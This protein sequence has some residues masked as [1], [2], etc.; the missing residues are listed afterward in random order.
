[1]SNKVYYSDM[2]SH[3]SH[4]RNDPFQA[5][6]SGRK[7]IESRLYD[8]KRQLITVGDS[9]TYINNDT[10]EQSVIV[11]VVE[12][13]RYDSFQELFTVHDPALFDGIRKEWLLNQIRQFYSEDE[14]K[15]YGVVGIRFQIERV[16]G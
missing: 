16:V 3:V 15:L 12:L 14:E 9:I 8:Q 4:I 6:A 5:I 7:T 13:L 10:P 2:S 1:M 11:R